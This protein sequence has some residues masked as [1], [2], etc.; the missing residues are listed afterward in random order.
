MHGYQFNQLRFFS[1][2]RFSWLNV[3]ECILCFSCQS[4]GFSVCRLEFETSLC[5]FQ[6]KLR[7][8]RQ[9]CPFVSCTQPVHTPLGRSVNTPPYRM[10]KRS[11]QN[12]FALG[13]LL[14]LASLMRPIFS[15]CCKSSQQCRHIS[16]PLE[17]L[18][19]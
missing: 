4:C 5:I 10:G 18:L 11:T 8:I 1:A 17:L 13:L 9:L 3:C 19:Q 6:P 16:S 7:L 15:L 2:I 14:G 12:M